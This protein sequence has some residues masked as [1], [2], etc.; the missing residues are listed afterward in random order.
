MSAC[1]VMQSKDYIVV[2][3]DS[4]VTLVT[5]SGEHKRLKEETEKLHIID[6][7]V[8]FASGSRL[9]I[10]NI[11][12]DFKKS[13]KRN[14]NTLKNIILKHIKEKEEFDLLLMEY[15]KNRCRTFQ[16]A[17]YN[18]FRIEEIVN[19]PQESTKMLTCGYSTKE[20]NSKARSIFKYNKHAINVIAE[21]F[22]HV[23][24]TEI[25]GNLKIL[26]ISKDGVKELGK[27][28]IEE[29][30]N[31]N[32]ASEEDIFTSLFNTV[33]EHV[34]LNSHLI[35][36]EKLAIVSEDGGFYIGSGRCSGDNIPTG[37][38]TNEFGMLVADKNQNRR[39]FIGIEED[40]LGIQEAKFE[41]R[42]KEGNKLVISD[43][44]LQM[45][46]QLSFADNLDSSHP[47]I[48]PYRVDEGIIEIRKAIITLS[49]Q[50]FRA[51]SKGVE[52]N[53]SIVQTVAGG[54]NNINISTGWLNKFTTEQVP[55]I[56]ENGVPTGGH[57]HGMNH[58][59]TVQFNN[60]H[61]HRI[62]I[63]GHTHENE[64]G[65]FEGSLPHNCSVFVNGVLV[66]SMINNSCEI[67]ITDYVVLNRVN[68]IKIT[69]ESM[70]RIVANV[71]IS[72]FSR[73]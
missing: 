9:L 38:Q 55:T 48:I 14:V 10:H 53:G 64:Y 67:D 33:Q 40:E 32:K 4:A 12:G 70:G 43:Q 47:M 25:G 20:L 57:A 13:K 44:G 51:Y 22:N 46:D 54:S 63:E 73:W 16:I 61:E 49:F 65:I 29:K 6:N 52:N 30:S 8:I 66:R 7:K 36:G 59:H 28:K 17:S 3:A 42:D 23:A 68:D 62:E 71:W 69:S 56:D 19:K 11:V 72:N 35:L 24:C 50:Q 15:S 5:T 31:I 18:D 45:K 37:L 58:N 39:I 26:L 41:L 21:S 34:T 27:Y 2:G 60:Y 1:L